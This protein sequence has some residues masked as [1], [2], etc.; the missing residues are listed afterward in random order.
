VLLLFIC[1]ANVGCID[2]SRISEEDF[3]LVL[4]N[5]ISGF[6]S[7]R[8]DIYVNQKGH[9]SFLEFL[10]LIDGIIE[11]LKNNEEVVRYRPDILDF[12]DRYDTEFGGP[13]AIDSFLIINYNSF[14]LNTLTKFQELTYI[15]KFVEL[16]LWNTSIG[17]GYSD[18]VIHYIPSDTILLFENTH[19]DIPIR[20]E[21]YE[22]NCGRYILNN[23]RQTISESKISFDTQQSDK[24][25]QNI[26]FTVNGKYA[27]ED[28][29]FTI[30]E[31]LT[32]KLIPNEFR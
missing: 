28:E 24:E 11:E 19:Y 25:Y 3:D 9:S 6:E 32:I 31:S 29:I 17:D 30:K 8:W 4:S 13:I 5:Y 7:K 26:D 14:K 23:S 16:I 15:D 2:G 10:P 18:I 21:T 22:N 12:I 20:V 1:F 27:W